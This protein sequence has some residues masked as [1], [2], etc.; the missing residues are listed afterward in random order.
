MHSPDSERHCSSQHPAEVC[1]FNEYGALQSGIVNRGAALM[2]E[3]ASFSM[4]NHRW[5]NDAERLEREVK[6]HPEAGNYE[7]SGVTSQLAV[8]FETLARQGVE[9]KYSSNVP[10][11]YLSFATRDMGFVVGKKFYV[12]RRRDYFRKQE[13]EGASELIEQLG[14]VVTLMS[15]FIEGGDVLVDYPNVFVGLSDRTDRTGMREL[16]SLVNLDGFEVLPIKLKQGVLHLDCCFNILSPRLAVVHPECMDNSGFKAI[17]RRFELIVLEES[18]RKYLSANV[19][20]LS[21]NLVISDARSERLNEM[22]VSKGLRVIPLLND[23]VTKM[24][25]SFRCCVL[26][27][28]RKSIREQLAPM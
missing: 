9:L 24:W 7:V 15:G 12:A 3:S 14:R 23:Q 17:E 28:N 11:M 20:M 5:P 4:I 27:L 13:I 26:P 6:L 19:L 10:D 18:D 2:P 8:F 16:S 25:G 22:L 21:E 1:V